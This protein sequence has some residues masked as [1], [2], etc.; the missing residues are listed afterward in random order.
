MVSGILAAVAVFLFC[1][2][3][4]NVVDGIGSIIEYEYESLL[5]QAVRVVRACLGAIA[6]IVA[7]AVLA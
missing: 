6:I 5:E 3:I 7:V 4:W 1:L 2:G